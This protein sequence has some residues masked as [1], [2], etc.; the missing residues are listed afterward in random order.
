MRFSGGHPRRRKSD[1]VDAGWRVCLAA[2]LLGVWLFLVAVMATSPTRGI[3]WLGY[4]LLLGIPIVLT[5]I[6]AAFTVNAVIVDR[7]W[8]RAERMAKEAD[9]RQSPGTTSE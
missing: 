5:V 6:F 4:S 1:L 2:S 7:S 8:L 3:E 9:V